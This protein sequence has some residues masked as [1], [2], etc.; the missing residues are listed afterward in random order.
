LCCS[1]FSAC[2]YACFLVGADI[3]RPTHCAR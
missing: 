1:E 3:L 2:N